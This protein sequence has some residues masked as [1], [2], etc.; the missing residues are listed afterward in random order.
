MH[1]QKQRLHVLK[2]ARG[3]SAELKKL[4]K[5]SHS[6]TLVRRPPRMLGRATCMFRELL[7]QMKASEKKIINGF[8]LISFFD[9]VKWNEKAIYR[10]GKSPGSGVYIFFL[11]KW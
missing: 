2:R 5:G 7:K 10:Y 11:Q 1:W 4:S 9:G 3:K 8:A 6:H